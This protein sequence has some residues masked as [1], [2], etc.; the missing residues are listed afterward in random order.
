MK[1]YAIP[2]KKKKEER[3]KETEKEKRKKKR[4]FNG[5]KKS[6]DDEELLIWNVSKVSPIFIR[7]EFLSC[8]QYGSLNHDNNGH[9]ILHHNKLYNC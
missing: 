8:N 3:E 5:P 9:E 4:R 2:F 6:A 1:R 7:H